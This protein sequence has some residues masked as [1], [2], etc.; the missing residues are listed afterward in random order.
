MSRLITNNLRLFNAEKFIQTFSNSN[1]YYLFV[2]VPNPYT[3]DNNPPELFDDQQDTFIDP[4]NYMAYG[5]RITS[6]DVIRMVRRVD[7][8]SNTLYSKYTQDDDNLSTKDFFVVSPEGGSYHVFKCL[9]NNGGLASNDQP[10]LSET[11]AEDDIY[12]TPND[13]Y[14]WKYMYSINSAQY[15]KFT[16]NTHIPY[17]ENVNVSS[18]AISGSID[19]IELTFAGVGYVSY[20]NGYFQDVLVDGEPTEFLIDSTTSSSNSNFYNGCAIKVTQG[21]G[22]GQQRK[23]VD[24][25]VDGTSR[26]VIVEDPFEVNPTTSSYYEITPIV[27]ITGDGSGAVARA[28]VNSSSNTIQRIEIVERGLG[29]SRATAT[30]FGN[31][32]LTP[33]ANLDSVT[34]TARVI[35]SPRGGHG[36]NGAAELFSR[37]VGVSVKV[38][39]TLSGGKVI[40]EN[41]FR[42]IGI[43]KDPLFA[44]VQINITE[45]SGI[46][47]AGQLITQDTS[48]AYGIVSFAN[49]TVVRLTNAYGIF[50]T[51]NN[52]TY[53]LTSNASS[54]CSASVTTVTFPNTYFDQ[55]TTL[56]GAIQTAQVFDEDEFATQGNAN[57]Q[58]Y[59][60]NSTVLKLYNTRGIFTTSLA[61]GDDSEA[62]INALSVTTPDIIKSSGDVLY[63][64][65]FA[66]ISRTSGQ[67]E[68]FKLIIEF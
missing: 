21:T 56:T 52:S 61:T 59:Y 22:I 27:N 51:G 45:A 28:I 58:V 13:N 43:L 19:N 50:Q 25:V 46:F 20:A 7:W 39:S 57:G 16:T 48:N 64:E 5:K 29:Y 65:N 62:S 60:S 54:A 3:D 53:I 37:Y 40:D 30:V 31:T 12:I 63:I 44:N 47:E 41:D 67:T 36:S 1:I 23:I 55:T 8:A 11:S 26:K 35:I 9:D 34:A 42:Q 38:D 66:P 33:L 17:Y 24:Y 68:T 49:S 18:N 10:L 6:S 14:Q 2:G 32:G 4:Y 15:T